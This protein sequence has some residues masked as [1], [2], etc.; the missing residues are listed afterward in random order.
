MIRLISERWPG[1]AN[2][3][4]CLEKML[5]WRHSSGWQGEIQ[6]APILVQL[7]VG[8]PRKGLQITSDYEPLVQVRADQTSGELTR[9]PL[10]DHDLMSPALGVGIRLP[11]D[12]T[13]E[14]VSIVIKYTTSLA[15][16]VCGLV[17]GGFHSIYCWTWSS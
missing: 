1:D 16:V 6:V 11:G 15:P 12:S 10:S 4:S 17:G 14:F 7:S 8:R 13:K 5:L 2:E 3:F 9:A